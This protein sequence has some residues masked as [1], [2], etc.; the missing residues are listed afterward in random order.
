MVLMSADE[1]ENKITSSN[2]ASERDE[3]V[4]RYSTRGGH[5]RSLPSHTWNTIVFSL[6]IDSVTQSAFDALRENVPTQRMKQ[7]FIAYRKARLERRTAIV[8]REMRAR[9][10]ARAAVATLLGTR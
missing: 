5:N 2:V 1:R 10:P 7:N 6:L 4:P 9:A 8:G 3:T